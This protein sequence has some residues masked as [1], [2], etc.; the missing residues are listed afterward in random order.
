MRFHRLIPL[1][2][3][4]LAGAAAASPS[5][6]PVEVYKSAF[7]GCC[8]QWVEHM[9]QAGFR[10]NVHETEDGSGARRRLG[11]PDRYAACHS[12]KAGDYLIEGHVPAGDVKRLLAERPKALGIAVPSMP[13]G[14]PGME[15]Q[16]AVPYQTLLIQADGA[17]LIF[18]RH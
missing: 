4:L 11:M 18:A 16:R 13:P 5:L 14:S 15:G 17:S 9:R 7:C 1:S 3:V 6:P 2:L 8:T 12:A 10:V